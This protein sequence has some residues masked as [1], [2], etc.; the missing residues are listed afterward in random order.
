[1]TNPADP[2]SVPM[3]IS[4]LNA[5]QENDYLF[6]LVSGLSK[7]ADLEIEVVDSDSSVHLFDS[8][9]QVVFF[10]LRGDNLSPQPFLVKL[11]RIARY[12]LRLITYAAKTRARL[13]HIE[14]DNSLKIFD[15]TL[16]ILYY[17]IL[18][19]KIVFTAHNVYREARD[20]RGNF[21]HWLSLKSLYRL[22]DRIIVHTEGMK[23]D[24]CSLFSIAPE[25]VVV[26]PHGVNIR[27]PRTGVGVSEA[28][29]K[30][31]IHSNAKVVLFF[32]LIDRYKGLELVIDAAAKLARD[33]PSLFLLVAGKPKR[34]SAYVPSLLDRIARKLPPQNVR[35]DL[36]FIP[37]SDVETY[38]AAADCLVLPYRR[39]YQSGVLFL[40]YRF[41]IPAI[42]ADVGNFREDVHEGVT[43]FISKPDSV[44]DL[45]A[46][47]A[48]FF[49]SDLFRR[50]E[51]TRE[52][53]I[54]QAERDYSWAD[55]GK[56]TYE[57]Y[58]SLLE[59]P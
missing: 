19:K 55:I 42:A 58:S 4:L 53:I 49:S 12:Y 56:R 50:R 48:I 41:G 18:A 3:R 52:R 34:K 27:I 39:I 8:F 9:P 23:A 28:R 31:G 43:G 47:L 40:A 17:K 32:G 59:T 29:A 14:W 33:D 26:I 15:R 24:L 36:D 10:N 37:V 5:G 44:E 1:M 20:E 45:A 46:K 38:F 57:V 21:V 51:Q 30:L 22:V 54:R 13:F 16:L 6:G 7:I 11:W 25:K 35:H 2:E